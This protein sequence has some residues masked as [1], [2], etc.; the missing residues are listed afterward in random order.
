[1]RC[2]GIFVVSPCSAC[3]C[4]GKLTVQGMHSGGDVRK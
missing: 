1:M 4:V 3:T 2:D